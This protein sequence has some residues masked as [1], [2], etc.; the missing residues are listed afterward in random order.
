VLY[1]DVKADNKKL[2]EMLRH[3]GGVRKVPVI[4][5]GERVTIGYGGS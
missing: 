1:F 3:S 4:L 5:E 2:E